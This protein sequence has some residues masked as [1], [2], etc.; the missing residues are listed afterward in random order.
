MTDTNTESTRP[1][2]R[3]EEE[4]ILEG[5]W[6]V[7]EQGKHAFTMEWF[8]GDDAGSATIEWDIPTLDRTEH[9]GLTFEMRTV[10]GRHVRAMT[11]YDGVFSLSEHAIKFIE[12][13]DIVVDPEFKS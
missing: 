2:Y 5:S 4:L 7:S 10:D 12:Q 11:E 8:E 3:G 13:Q 1:M 9:I 6:G